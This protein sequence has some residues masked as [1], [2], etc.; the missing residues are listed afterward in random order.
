MNSKNKSSFSLTVQCFFEFPKYV[1][2]CLNISGRNFFFKFFFTKIILLD[3]NNKEINSPFI[4]NISSIFL[5][6]KKY[7]NYFF[8]FLTI[9]VLEFFFTNL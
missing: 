5:P 1:P 9:I 8:L 6:N 2:S 7:K 3:I 4:L